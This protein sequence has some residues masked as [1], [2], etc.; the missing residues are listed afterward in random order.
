M[1]EL[2]TNVEIQSTVLEKAEEAY[3]ERGVQAEK[4]YKLVWEIRLIHNS[5][6]D[7]WPGAAIN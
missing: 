4:A 7:Y 5:H 6:C 2:R 3:K 1:I